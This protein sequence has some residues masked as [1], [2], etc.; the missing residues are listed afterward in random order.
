MKGI[1]ST[2]LCFSRL[3]AKCSDKSILRLGETYFRHTFQPMTSIPYRGSLT[4]LKCKKKELGS[5]K[6][7]IPNPIKR[8][9]NNTILVEQTLHFFD[10]NNFEILSEQNNFKK[11]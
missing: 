3:K 10:F 8:K 2:F 11:N 6:W 7:Y 1:H 5:G 9:E 4:T